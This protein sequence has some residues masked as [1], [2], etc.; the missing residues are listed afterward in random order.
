MQ[1]FEQLGIDPLLLSAQVLNFLLVLLILWRFLYRPILKI[2]KNR[3]ETIAKSLKE[4]KEISAE[5]K[6]ADQKAK[7]IIS[8]ATDKSQ[9]ILAQG[10]KELAERRVE[11]MRLADNEAA[12]IFK[13]AEQAL[14]DEKLK[15]KKELEEQTV[16]LVLQ[17]SQKVIQQS[18]DEKKQR[19]L[20][21]Q[22]IKDLA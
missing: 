11:K 1:L 13:R 14:K 7:K 5:L 15:A 8:E 17:A 20:I 12:Q 10:E 16:D 18:L 9:V 21:K 19:A 4:A 2:L 6:V 22:A 3:R